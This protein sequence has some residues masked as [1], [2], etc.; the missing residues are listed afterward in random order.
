MGRTSHLGKVI[1]GDNP[2]IGRYSASVAKIY[3]A[4]GSLM[5]FGNKNIFVDLEKTL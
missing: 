3:N 1:P 4:K 5:P 2:T